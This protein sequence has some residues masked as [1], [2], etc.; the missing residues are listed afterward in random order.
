[1]EIRKWEKLFHA[2][3]N[4][5]K[6]GIAIHRAEKIYLKTQSITRGKEGHKTIIKNSIH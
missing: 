6:G 4:E 5:K 2:K 3:G 1:M